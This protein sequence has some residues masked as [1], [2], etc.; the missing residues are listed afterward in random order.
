MFWRFDMTVCAYLLIS[1]FDN[2]GHCSVGK[3]IDC[4]LFYLLRSD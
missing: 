4:S 3:V 1:N 2:S